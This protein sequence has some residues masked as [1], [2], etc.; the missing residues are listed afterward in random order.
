MSAPPLDRQ[1]TI[2]L[3]R[4]RENFLNHAELIFGRVLA[5]SPD[6]P[7]AQRYLGVTL[8]KLGR[9]EEGLALLRAVA[10]RTPRDAGVQ[11]DLAAALAGPGAAF[12]SDHA[13]HDF[14]TIDYSYRAAIRYGAGK[15]AH[16][17]LAAL[18]A[19]GA[20]RYA[21]VLA[22]IARIAHDFDDIALGGTYDTATPF[23][24]N[25]WF[26]PLDGL[27]LTE[28]LRAH[29]PARFVE[30]GS[31][32]STKFARRA[33]TRYGLRA[34]LTSIDPQPRNE[35]DAL[36]DEVI[37]SPLED[38]DLD[39]FQTLTAGDILFLDSSH[40]AFQ[41]SDVTVF[42]L[43]ILPRLAPGVIVQVHDIY[44]PDDYIAGHVGRLWNEQYLLAT[45]LLFGGD[46]F[47]VMFP[48]WYV[49]QDPTL[50][51]QALAAL[52]GGPLAT[53]NPYGASFWFRK[54]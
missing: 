29:D 50:R 39:L 52:A 18:I 16:P 41:G 3:A 14:K 47:Q 12:T 8:C 35:I 48:S 20:A 9:G 36:C 51:A 34:H 26:P 33:V 22:G 44:L 10:T 17:E 30:I 37:R 28:M 42:F 54:T 49:G 27:V 31:G 6:H 7:Q 15:P 25:T 2:G 19:A 46:A 43:E 4:L 38:C 1:F 24:L 53:L 21:D 40:R 32:V 5:A 13:T 11:A 23:W 45:A